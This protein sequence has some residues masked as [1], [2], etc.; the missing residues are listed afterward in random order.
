MKMQNIAINLKWR[1]Y[2]SPSSIRELKKKK[3]NNDELGPSPGRELATCI[4]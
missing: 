2:N 4:I 1:K 3:E